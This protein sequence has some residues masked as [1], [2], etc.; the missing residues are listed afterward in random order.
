M[1][2]TRADFLL[3]MRGKFTIICAFQLRGFLLLLQVNDTRTGHVTPDP[4]S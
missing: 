2:F 1:S 3:P 4:I